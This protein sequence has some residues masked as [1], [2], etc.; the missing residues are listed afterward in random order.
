MMD[1]DV[2]IRPVTETEVRELGTWRN[3]PPY[4]V[5]DIGDESVDGN[6]E[7]LMGPETRCHA[8]VDASGDLIGFCT[9]GS[10]ARVPGGDYSAPA[11][12]IGLGIR[13]DRTGLG[14]GSRHVAAVADFAAA[15]FQPE[16]MRVTISEWNKR[17]QRVWENAG[18]ERT[19]RFDTPE[20]FSGMGG[21]AFIVFV[22]SNAP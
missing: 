6:I 3:D 19:E 1:G 16:Q 10:D 17:A 5:Y 18:F 20:D 8:L 9:F 14:N 15:A 11:L 22:R 13:P 12:D 7:Y 4:D 2:T 21:G